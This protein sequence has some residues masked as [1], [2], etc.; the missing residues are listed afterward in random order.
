MVIINNK[1]RLDHNWEF[2]TTSFPVDPAKAQDLCEWLSAEPQKQM[3]GF[4]GATA[5]KDHE[6]S[7]TT[8]QVGGRIRLTPAAAGDFQFG[9]Q[10]LVLTANISDDTQDH[11]AISFTS[12]AGLDV[13]QLRVHK[14]ETIADLCH[15][16]RVQPFCVSS[17]VGIVL[18]EGRALGSMDGTASVAT[19]VES[20]EA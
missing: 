6:I 8:Y 15:T 10:Y 13:L 7:E 16:V 1:A 19:L 14:T 18:P 3:F 20:A 4:V 5:T 12:M 9:Q 11:L 2:N 17:N